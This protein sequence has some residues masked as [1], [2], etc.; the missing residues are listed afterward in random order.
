MPISDMPISG[1][2]RAPALAALLAGAGLLALAACD[3]ATMGQGMGATA[4]RAKLDVAGRAVTIAAPAGFCIDPES[5]TS[6]AEGAFVLMSDCG[7]MGK[8]DR[9]GTPV[10]AAMTASVSSGGFAGEGDTAAGSLEELQEFAATQEGRTVLGRSG[11]PDRVRILNTQLS[12]GVLYVLVEDRGAQPIAGI[13]RQFWRAFLEVN[14]RLV[15]LSMLGFQG[16]GPGPQEA[17]NQLAALARATQA[18]NAG[19]PASAAAPS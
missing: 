6:S 2:L 12:G 18:A 8:D 13:E 1:R 19:Q 3:P 11:Q 9:K 5:V 7:L 17:L 10:G 15:A 14:G 16:A 4:T